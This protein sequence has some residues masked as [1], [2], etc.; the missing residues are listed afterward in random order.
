M[1]LLLKFSAIC[2]KNLYKKLTLS[3]VSV[4]SSASKFILAAESY[5][6]DSPVK[7][8]LQSPCRFNLIIKMYY[9]YF[10]NYFIWIVQY[11]L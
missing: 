9:F 6:W 10:C 1:Y 3:S 8:F 7:L 2:K 5:N 11:F 4:I